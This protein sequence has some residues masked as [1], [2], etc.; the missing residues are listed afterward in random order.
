MG[1]NVGDDLDRLVSR[2]SVGRHCGHIRWKG[3]R[4]R[5]G[6]CTRSILQALGLS[7]AAPAPIRHAPAPAA[8][9]RQASGNFIAPTSCCQLIVERGNP[10]IQ[11]IEPRSSPMLITL[12]G[13]PIEDYVLILADPPYSAEDA[14]HSCTPLVRRSE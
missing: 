2:R 10:A 13:V 3:S 5:P 9:R 12:A 14:D 4:Q 8:D 6:C 11:P 1:T 7:S